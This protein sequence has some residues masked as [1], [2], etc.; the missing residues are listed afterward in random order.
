MEEQALFRIS[1]LAGTLCALLPDAYDHAAIYGAISTVQEIALLCNTEKVIGLVLAKDVLAGVICRRG[2]EARAK[3]AACTVIAECTKS[4]GILKH[5]VL[6]L[7]RKKVIYHLL[8]LVRAEL[9]TTKTY[10]TQ[11]LTMYTAVLR[12][13]SG[14]NAS[15]KTS[16][17]SELYSAGAFCLLNTRVTKDLLLFYNELFLDMAAGRAPRLAPIAAGSS[18]YRSPIEIRKK[19]FDSLLTYTKHYKYFRPCLFRVSRTAIKKDS[20]YAQ[21]LRFITE[22]NVLQQYLLSIAYDAVPDLVHILATFLG[23]GATRQMLYLL[24]KVDLFGCIRHTVAECLKKTERR[25]LYYSL[26]LLREYLALLL[27]ARH[28]KKSFLAEKIL[29]RNVAKETAFFNALSAL[30]GK[31]AK[32]SDDEHFLGSKYA[33][34]K[35]LRLLYA[36]DPDVSL[37][38]HPLGVV[39][40]A[41]ILPVTGA[42]STDGA[43]HADIL[44]LLSRTQRTTA[45]LRPS[46]VMLVSQLRTSAPNPKTPEGEWLDAF[47]NDVYC[48]YKRKGSFIEALYL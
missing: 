20:V 32:P 9:I 26:T 15:Y 12:E 24:V 6:L 2:V 29:A 27:R 43:Y 10:N 39:Y 38:L 4:G 41:E 22:C 47:F 33:V 14:E 19:D 42:L 30:L 21:I 16:I 7:A 48:Y 18:S 36:V 25:P 13:C 8:E 5:I 40:A 34:V 37:A 1:E 45:L 46:V 35:I 11:I 28:K 44:F 23:T 3:A 31:K 17:A